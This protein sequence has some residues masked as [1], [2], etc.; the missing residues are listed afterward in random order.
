[1]IDQKTDH[2]PQTLSS[3]HKR[4]YVLNIFL[5]ILSVV[6]ICFFFIGY[7]G[8][9]VIKIKS[10]LW[11]LWSFLAVIFRLITPIIFIIA[12]SCT[13]YLFFQLCRQGRNC[14]PAIIAAIA[15]GTSLLSLLS[16]SASDKLFYKSVINTYGNIKVEQKNWTGEALPGFTFQNIKEELTPLTV[17]NLQGKPSILIFWATYNK[18][19]SS[20]F[21][22]AQELYSQR[23]KLNVNVF[24]IAIDK[25]KED[26]KKFLEKYTVSMPVFHNPDASYVYNRLGLMRSPEKV[27]II[28]SMTRIQ[29]IF[30]SPDNAD[31]IKTAL[32]KIRK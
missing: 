18:P 25:S 21:K 32:N 17:D 10:G 15:T 2:I 1:M 26:I 4:I 29:F 30:D 20:N 24:A 23:E 5:I 27:I 16:I 9:V 22:Y 12:I 7:I 14:K 8:L 6:E 19:W 31:E 28:D 11:Y 13:I 3:F